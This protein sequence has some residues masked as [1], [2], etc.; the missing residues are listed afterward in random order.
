MANVLPTHIQKELESIRRARFIIAGSL[1]AIVAAALSVLALLP[2]YVALHSNG[3]TNQS[4]N[5]HA[6]SLGNSDRDSLN[7]AKLFLTA[8]APII[9]AT[10]TPSDTIAD[11]LSLRPTGLHVTHIT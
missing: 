2:G 11:A 4:T 8:L 1:V 5:P 6:S 7:R 3:D 9:S 10:T